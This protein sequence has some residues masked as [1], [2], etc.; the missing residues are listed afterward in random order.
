[1]TKLK[2]EPHL[3]L[4]EFDLVF[5][6]RCNGNQRRRTVVGRCDDGLRFCVVLLFLWERKSW[7]VVVVVVEVEE[8]EEE[9]ITIQ[10]GYDDAKDFQEVTLNLK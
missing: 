6:W 4:G 10:G 7:G 2:W 9:E 8:D 5:F 3:F 1:M